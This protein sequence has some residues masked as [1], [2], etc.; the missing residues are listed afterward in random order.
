MCGGTD[1]LLEEHIKIRGVLKK[2]MEPLPLLAI[3]LGVLYPLVKEVSMLPMPLQLH[4]AWARY[5][6][7]RGYQA[8]HMDTEYFKR[9]KLLKILE[10]C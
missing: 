3:C 2:R 9:Y 5:V 4:F 1:A 10:T 7:S 8:L 6:L